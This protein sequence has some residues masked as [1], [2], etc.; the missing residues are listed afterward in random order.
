MAT[1]GVGTR[2]RLLV[3]AE[4]LIDGPTQPPASDESAEGRIEFQFEQ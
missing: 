1:K 3:A 4:R 2:E